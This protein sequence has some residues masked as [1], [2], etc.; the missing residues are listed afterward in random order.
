MRTPRPFPNE[1]PPA[2]DKKGRSRPLSIALLIVGGF[3]LWLSKP[4]ALISQ[5]SGDDAKRRGC[6]ANLQ[7]ISR[8]FAQY[9]QDYDG[10]FPRGVDAEDRYNPALWREAGNGD[11][12][13]AALE[14]PLLPDVLRPYLPDRSAWKCPADHGYAHSSLPV[15]GSSLTDVFP[16]A[17]AKYGLSYSYF[18]I[19][20]FAQKRARDAADPGRDVILFDSD[21]WHRSDNSATI[22]VLFGDGHT[23]NITAAAYSELTHGPDMGY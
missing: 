10:K 18:T 2:R 19:H 15:A 4:P 22:N 1:T 12:H 9:A 3:G 13:Q 8:A 17:Y 16:S 6:L 11:F 20:G 21:L 14:A 5:T 7:R 23:Q